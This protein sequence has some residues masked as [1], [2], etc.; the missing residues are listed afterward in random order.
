MK[1]K[2]LLPAPGAE[3]L[4][5]TFLNNL[6]LVSNNQKI[7]QCFCLKEQLISSGQSVVGVKPKSVLELLQLWD[8]LHTKKLLSSIFSEFGLFWL[9]ISG[10]IS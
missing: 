2:I 5:F 8:S 10:K 7:E 9:Q 1:N 4:A 3:R 6:F